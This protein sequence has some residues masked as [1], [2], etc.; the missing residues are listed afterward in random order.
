MSGRIIAIETSF[1]D[2]AIAILDGGA[3]PGL[4]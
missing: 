3:R 2:A 4:G 1:D